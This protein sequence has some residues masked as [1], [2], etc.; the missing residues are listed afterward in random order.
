MKNQSELNSSLNSQKLNR[1]NSSKRFE[2]LKQRKKTGLDHQKLKI[3]I[4]KNPILSKI[5][6][7]T[8]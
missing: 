7:I 2:D 6:H 8:L 5:R 4:E 1:K 3:F